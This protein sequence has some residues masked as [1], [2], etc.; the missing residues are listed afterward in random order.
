METSG[1]NT[2]SASAHARALLS[3]FTLPLMRERRF[4]MPWEC[5][6]LVWRALG[7]SWKSG[8]RL[9]LRRYKAFR[10]SF[11]L[12]SRFAFRVHLVRSY[13]IRIPNRMVFSHNLFVT[14]HDERIWMSIYLFSDT[15]DL[16]ARLLTSYL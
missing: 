15:Y 4:T 1:A 12:P 10:S 6:K 14:Y 11:K 2:L 9:C 13:D 7:E 8:R 3:A 16:F 5:K